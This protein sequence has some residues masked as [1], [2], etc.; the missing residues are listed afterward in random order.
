MKKIK[1]ALPVQI[2][3]AL[4]LGVAFGVF[5][6]E[7]VKYI[8]WAGEMFLRFLKMIVV[9]IVF[10]SMVTGVASLGN[11]GGL[12]RIAGKTFGFYIC[13]TVVATA[14]GLVLVNVLQP[15]VGS[16]LVSDAA[17]ASQLASAEKV[18]LGQQIIN[19]IPNNVFAALTNG[20]LLQVIFF[21]ILFGFFVTKVEDK[22]RNTIVDFFQAGNDV[23]MKITLAVIN[24]APYGVFSIVAKM[25][26]QQAGDMDKLMGVAQSL[27]MFLL[28][29]WAGCM[30]H[31]FIVLP[32]TVYFIGKENPW[33][34]MKKMSTAILTAF[35]TCSSGAALPISMKDSQEKCGISN[36]I[37]GFTLPLGATIN[38][39]GTAL[40]EGVAVIFIA[41]VYGIDLSI[42]E[43]IIIL[44][45]V[46]FSAIGAASIPMAGLV[47]LSVAISVAGL[48]MEGIGLVLA[49]E[50]LCDMPR[51]AT[52][53]YG[54]MCGAVVIAKSEGEKL[55]I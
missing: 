8:S 20:D 33:R 41:Q 15:G 21:A 48:P 46:L 14:I 23:I 1:I 18:S 29:V 11:Q 36:K 12:G 43:Q 49:V 38:M 54:D 47:M 7:Y 19:I 52:N 25:I 2:L 32:C 9:P 39:N 31:F 45:T 27:G 42:M 51:T 35:S 24:L 34:H 55:T 13:T 50:Q 44:V 5:F 40:Y 26:S 10:C 4:V 28:I 16:S 3:I 37:A 6:H 30:I 17:A 53:S 22:A